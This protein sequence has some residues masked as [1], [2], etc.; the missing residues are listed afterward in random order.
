MP[1]L[2]YSGDYKSRIVLYNSF[3]YAEWELISSGTLSVNKLTFVDLYLIGGGGEGAQSTGSTSYS[4]GGGSGYPAYT[5]AQELGMGNHDV[6]IGGS[7]SDTTFSVGNTA[8][9]YRGRKGG[10]AKPGTTADGNAAVGEGYTGLYYLYNDVNYPCG[11]GGGAAMGTAILPGRGGGGCPINPPLTPPYALDSNEVYTGTSG[12]WN[13][14]PI[15]PEYYGYGAGGMGG[16]RIMKCY[17]AQG[18]NSGE[19]T[20][21]NFL[22]QAAQGVA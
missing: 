10:N 5:I 12:K 16:A 4:P 21:V 9:V 15:K 3:W 6:V 14:V 18:S 7:H 1:D 13:R 8:L 19:Y 2:I 11:T 20:V 17:P 22:P